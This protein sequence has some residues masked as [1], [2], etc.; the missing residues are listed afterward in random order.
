VDVR[1]RD[2]VADPVGEAARVTAALDLPAAPDAFAA[3]LARNR[4]QRHGSHTYTAAD[5]GLSVPELEQD[6]AFYKEVM[7]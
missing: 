4:R 7:P 6:F 2:V 5:F 3:Y 1:F